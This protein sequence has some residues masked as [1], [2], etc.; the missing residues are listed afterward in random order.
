MNPTAQ[1]SLDGQ[2]QCE[3]ADGGVDLNRNYGV[4]WGVGDRVPDNSGE[5]TLFD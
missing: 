2:T 4:D 3:E 1:S 5:G